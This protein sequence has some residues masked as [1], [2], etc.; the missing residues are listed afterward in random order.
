MHKSVA[1]ALLIIV[2]GLFALEQNTSAQTTEFTYQ[3]SLKDG[4]NPANGNYD[5]EFALFDALSGGTQIGSTLN[6][7]TVNVANGTFAIKLDFG[8]QFPGASRFLEIRVRQG[9]GNQFTILTPRQAINSSPYSVKSIMADA[10]STAVNF[11]G[12]L[13]GDV[14]GTQ[15]NT[16]VTKLRGISISSSTPQNGQALIYNSANNQWTPASVSNGL[17]TPSH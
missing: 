13:A 3:G 16:T 11:S 5:F 1:V 2:V 15:E 4:V 12:N 6:R 9:S 14:A 10:A 8:S 17:P 7:N